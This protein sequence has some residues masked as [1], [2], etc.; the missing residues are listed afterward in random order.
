MDPAT[1]APFAWRFRRH[2]KQRPAATARCVGAPEAYG[3]STNLARSLSKVTLRTRKVT[4]G[5]IEVWGTFV[6]K[7]V[8]LPRIGSRLNPH[9]ALVMVWTCATL[10]P[11]Y[12]SL[13]WSDVSTGQ[14]AG[15]SWI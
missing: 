8:E 11:G 13:S 5:V 15:N 4:S 9:P 6:A 14:T 2:P 7:P 10:N 12:W 3:P 1:A